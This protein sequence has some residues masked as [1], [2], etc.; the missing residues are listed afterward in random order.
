[1]RHRQEIADEAKALK[2]PL[3]LLNY[4]LQITHA[5]SHVKLNM[6]DYLDQ[7]L[8]HLPDCEPESTFTNCRFFG[9]AFGELD[10]IT[11]EHC[12]FLHCNFASS[13][14]SETQF[15]QCD[16]YDRDLEQGTSFRFAQLKDCG[17]KQCDLTLA[18]FSRTHLYLSEFPNCQLTGASFA[19]ATSCQ[20][21]GSSVEVSAASFANSNLAYT[22]F[23]GAR[24]PEVDFSGCR[25]SHVQLEGADLSSANLTDCDMHQIQ[26][27][28]LLLKHA[29]LRG[30]SISG[31]DVRQIDVEG[32][33]IDSTQASLLLE[34][35]GMQI[36]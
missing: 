19:A 26:A 23:S 11:F 24:L 32:V 31:L 7:T 29:D 6:T 22:D 30:A 35:L 13:L 20:T 34:A 1:M 2:K 15:D 14:C 5:Q 16:F 21:I 9:I 27:D 10:A 33:R 4:D 25:M 36:D 12:Q 17:F 18:D 28:R 8:D 3:R